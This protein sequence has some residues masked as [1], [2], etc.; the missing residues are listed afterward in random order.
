MDVEEHFSFLADLH[1]QIRN[2]PNGARVQI[3]IKE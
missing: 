1:A 2:L 3:K